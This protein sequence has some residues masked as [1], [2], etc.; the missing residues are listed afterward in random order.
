MTLSLVFLGLR[1]DWQTSMYGPGRRL[2]T[3]WKS[4]SKG[5]LDDRNCDELLSFQ[6][7]GNLPFLF[8]YIYIRYLL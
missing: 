6:C 7:G 1:Q 5:I 8:L 4:K 3:R 2:E